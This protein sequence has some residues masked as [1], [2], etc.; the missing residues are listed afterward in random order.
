MATSYRAIAKAFHNGNKVRPGD[1][2]TFDAKFGK[3]KHPSWIDPT[4]VGAKKAEQ[5]RQAA[6]VRA[7]AK[8]QEKA[9][10]DAQVA[11]AT[12]VKS[13]TAVDFTQSVQSDANGGTESL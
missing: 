6:A 7:A 2:V 9:D 3:G 11:D 8:R 13:D 5:E 10:N 4:P 1:I 12:G